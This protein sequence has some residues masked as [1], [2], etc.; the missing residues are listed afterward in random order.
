[1]SEQYIE[2]RI[3][4]HFN[5]DPT[6]DYMVSPVDFARIEQRLVAKVEHDGDHQAFMT[7]YMPAGLTRVYS[8]ADAPTGQFVPR[9]RLRRRSAE[10]CAPKALSLADQLGEQLLRSAL[11]ALTDRTDYSAAAMLVHAYTELQDS[12]ARASF[13]RPMGL[14]SGLVIRD[15]R[16]QS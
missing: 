5:A 15:A 1:V 7:L 9:V 10:S 12:I 14:D 16:E 6:H 3:R 8:D 13:G 11:K 4:D 2:E